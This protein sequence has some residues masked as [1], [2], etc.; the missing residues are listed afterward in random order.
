M[1]NRVPSYFSSICGIMVASKST[2][3]RWPGGVG[4]EPWSVLLR[5]VLSSILSDVNF[6]GLD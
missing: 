5:K 1:H 4:F 6:G 3:L 2:H